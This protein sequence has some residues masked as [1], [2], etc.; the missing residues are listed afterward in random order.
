M[1]K[2]LLLI[3]T[4]I[5]SAG[6]ASAQISIKGIIKS[7]KGT[8]IPNATVVIRGTKIT[9]VADSNGVFAINTKQEPPFYLQISS[10]GYKAQDFQILKVQDMLFMNND[11]L[12]AK[13]L[14]P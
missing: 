10:V 9:T 11:N 12:F 5:L 14:F 7:D 1:K 13:S 8:P 4:L 2:S 6:L 3:F